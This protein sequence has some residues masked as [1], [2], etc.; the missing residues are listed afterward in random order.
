MLIILIMPLKELKAADL[1]TVFNYCVFIQDRKSYLYMVIEMLSLSG[2]QKDFI[3]NGLTEIGDNVL[4]IQN[5]L[6]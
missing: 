6:Q 3:L 2:K 5:L 4:M 1:K